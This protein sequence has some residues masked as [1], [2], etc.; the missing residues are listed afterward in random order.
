MRF[1]GRRQEMWVRQLDVVAGRN[2]ACVDG[3]KDEE[4]E[5]MEN[6]HEEDEE[7]ELMESGH[8]EDEDVHAWG[9]DVDID[10]DDIAHVPDAE[11]VHDA[12]G[13]DDSI[14]LDAD[15]INL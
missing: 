1:G 10:V 5:H 9:D 3:E 13:D 8:E 7:T 14:D 4:T 12:W 15:L 6:G 2:V 11:Q